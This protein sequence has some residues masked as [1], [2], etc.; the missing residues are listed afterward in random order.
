MKHR[1]EAFLKEKYRD[2]CSKIWYRCNGSMAQGLFASLIV[3]LILKVLG[4][5]LDLYFID[6]GI[7]PCQ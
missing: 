6:L 1:R 2:I 7:R 5:K 3:G 4:E